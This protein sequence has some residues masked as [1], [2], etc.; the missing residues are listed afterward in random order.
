MYVT[1]TLKR[2]YERVTGRG[3]PTTR[4]VRAAVARRRPKTFMFADDGTI[5]NNPDVPVLLY[6]QVVD[7]ARAADPAAVFEEL[8]AAND[9]G[10]S[11]RN[12]IYDY[13]HYH[14]AIHEALGIAR[15]RAR[16]R[17]GGE[18]GEEVDLEAGDVV[19]LPAGT[20]HQCLMQSE[21]FLVVGA[22]P[23]SGEYDLCRGSKADHEKALAAIPLCPPPNFDPVYGKSGPLTKHWR[24]ALAHKKSPRPTA[25][26][27][28]KLVS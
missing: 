18:K 1:E 15:G 8:F 21:D 12:G 26:R 24:D 22:Y 5:P 13:V 11:W 17:L 6:P 23:P 7:L 14:S 27:R 9:W 10:E 20:G 16:V 25:T 19:V 2:A 4:Q 28:D 3:K